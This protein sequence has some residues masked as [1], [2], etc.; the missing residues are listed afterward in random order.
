MRANTNP[1]DQ[2]GLLS[3]EPFMMTCTLMNTWASMNRYAP[4]HPISDAV[5]I[6]PQKRIF[7][8]RSA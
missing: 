2:V 7:M 6:A 1:T 4:G 8:K 5:P 3:D